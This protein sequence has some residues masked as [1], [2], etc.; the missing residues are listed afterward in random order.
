LVV[1]LGASAQ[2]TSTPNDVRDRR[3]NAHA[4]THATVTTRPGNILEDATILV[5]EGEIVSVTTAGEVPDGYVEVDLTG[6][7]VYAGLIDLNSGYGLGDPAPRVPFSFSAAEVLQSPTPGAYNANQA[8]RSHYRA[9]AH[10]SADDEKAGKY[11]ELGFGAVLTHMADGIARG[12]GALVSTGSSNDNELLIKGDAAAHYSFNKGSS[13]QSYP[14]SPMGAIALLRQTFMDARWYSAQDPKPFTDESLEAWLAQAALPQIFDAGDWRAVLGADGVGDEFGVQYIIK[15]GGNEYHRIQAIADTGAAMIIDVN[16]PDSKDVSD[17]IDAEAIEFAE[18]KH[19]E[20]APTNP[21]ALSAAGIRFAITSAADTKAFWSNLRKAIKHGLSEQAALAALTTTPAS[22]L[23]VEDRLG[24][25]E[26]GA[27]ANLLVTSGPLFEEDTVIQENW[28]QGARHT[29]ARPPVD[30]S[31]EYQVSVADAGSW[32][33]AVT[34]KPGKHKAAIAAPE[35]EQADGQ[36]ETEE[37]AGAEENGQG[38]DTPVE[39]KFD[40]ELV[41][42]SFAP[43]KDAPAIRLSGW[44]ADKRWHGRGQLGDGTWV[45][46]HAERLADVQAK[47]EN[48]GDKQPVEEDLALGSVIVPFQAYGHTTPPS[49]EN[50]LFRNA[51]VWTSDAAGILSGTDVLVEAGKIAAV[52]SNLDGGDA[53]VVDATGKHL[54]A[55]I[56]DE[57]AH[58]ALRGVND[59]AVNSSMVRMADVVNSEDVNIYRNLAGGVTAAQL[60]HGSANPVGG[61]SALVKYRWG[62]LPKQM[63][64]QGAD[65]FI[66]FALGENVKRSRNPN[67]IRYP[68]TRMGVEQVYRDGFSAARDY[69]AAWDEY[70]GLSRRQQSR[71]PP[72]RQDLV[73]DTMAEIIAGER[74]ITCHSYVQSEINMLMHVAEDFDFRINTF[75]HILEGYKVADKMAAHGAG[76]STFADWWAYKWEVRYAIPYNPTL[77]TEAGVTVAINSDSGEMSRRL[78]QEAAKSVKYGGMSDE[79][80]LKMITINPARLLHLDDRMGSIREGKDADLVL[81]DD[82]PLSIYAAAEMTLVDGTVYYDRQADAR[83]R[84]EIRAERAR[85]IAKMAKHPP[86]GNGG[87]PGGGRGSSAEQLWQCDSLTGFEYLTDQ[88]LNQ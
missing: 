86:K 8:I 62:A 20:L 40:Q 22:L 79:D 9:A 32:T 50:I 16:F 3:A 11:R 60:L 72:P 27:I 63:L 39:I 1:S 51:T 34:G 70:N 49:A 26:G 73:M 19:W 43:E 6:R 31:G 2:E 15:G 56:I 76:G 13:A 55:G 54:T 38:K 46:W 88:W 10:F 41:S 74:F 48:E 30:H 36:D 23:G 44:M 33:V 18:L 12:S 87:K 75:T 78:N 29:L 69:R 64:I 4:L 68:Q 14:I 35:A 25:L 83:M 45:D 66:K 57:H 37:S 58:I 28:V 71:T 61:Q 21:A 67:S 7:Y 47:D 84:D 59:I 17:P 85:L 80:A 77:M 52:G 65:G 81:W 24:H 53:R 82:Q 42:L 5:R